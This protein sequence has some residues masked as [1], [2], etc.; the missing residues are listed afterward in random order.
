MGWFRLKSLF[1]F[2]PELLAGS[3]AQMNAQE[4]YRRNLEIA[5][6]LQANAP[7]NNIVVDINSYDS[8]ATVGRKTEQAIEK[9]QRRFGIDPDDIVD[10]EIIE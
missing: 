7:Q 5:A 3:Q 4:Q 10:G 9:S 1:D 6:Y 2:T 8:P